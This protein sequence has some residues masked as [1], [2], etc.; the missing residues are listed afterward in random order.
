MESKVKNEV[1]EKDATE[2][3]PEILLKGRRREYSVLDFI[4]G[5][6]LTNSGVV[7][8]IPFVLFMVLIAL[9]YISN[10]YYAEK[11]MRRTNK[12][13]NEIKELRSEFITSKSDLMFNS[14]QSEVAR[15]AELMNTGLKES[16]VA[17]KKIIIE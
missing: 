4:N 16:R 17:P 3:D 8:Q 10:T 13:T 14:K 7:K 15:T 9:V 2:K 11:T 6:F 1:L 5:S 12:I